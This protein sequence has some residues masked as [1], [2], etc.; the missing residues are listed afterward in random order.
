MTQQRGT[1]NKRNGSWGFR[2]SYFD[3]NGKRHWITSYNKR[4][5]RQDAQQQLTAKLALLD[6]G[7]ALGTATGSIGDYL[8]QWLTQHV[9]SGAVKQTTAETL[10]VHVHKYLI[11]AIG[12]RRLRDLKPA[13]VAS[14]YADLLKHGRTGAGIISRSSQPLSPKTVRNIAGTLHHALSD[15]VRLGVISKNPTTDVK[16]PR[17][18][19]PELSVWDEQQVAQYLVHC[20]DTADPLYAVWRLLL[21]VGLR[22]GELLGLTWP[23]VDL[24]SAMITVKQT[25][26]LL[27]D[28]S[29]AVETPKTK[30]GRRRF[31]IDAETVTA[32]AVLKN[33]HEQAAD[34]LPGWSSPYVATNADGQPIYPTTLTKRFRR[35]AQAAGLPVIRLHDGRHTAATSALQA[36]VSVHVVSG[37]L[38]HSKPSTTLDVYSHFLPTADRAAA[39]VVGFSLQAA[40]DKTVR[41][42]NAH[43]MRTEPDKMRTQNKTRQSV[44]FLEPLQNNENRTT[45]HT[46]T[47]RPLGFEPRTCGL[48]VRCSTS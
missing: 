39:D 35:T 9:A 6:A 19:R 45:Q 36:G 37:R 33:A 1:L 44:E 43:T 32:L 23:D 41:S 15:A 10:S 24:V 28:S 31:A 5:N 29:V 48:R 40:I 46:T 3:D 2:V 42:Q 4:W 11:P 17:Y 18:E 25:R 38:G 21:V 13:G 47:V 14:L 30:R 27:A 26:V 34:I 16:L 7:H 8:V 22:R 20:I 12:Q